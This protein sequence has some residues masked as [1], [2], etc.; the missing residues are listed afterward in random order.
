M[1]CICS[2]AWCRWTAETAPHTFLLGPCYLGLLSAENW[3][4]EAGR[5][6][7]VVPPSLTFL[8][9]MAN[10]HAMYGGGIWTVVPEQLVVPAAGPSPYSSVPSVEDC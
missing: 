2:D 4:R 3:L 10:R 9:D 6:C 1:G 5:G 7:S 8:P